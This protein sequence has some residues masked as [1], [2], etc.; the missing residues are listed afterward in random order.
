MPI[1]VTCACGQSFAANDSLAGKRVK[2]PK[3]AQPLQIPAASAPGVAQPMGPARPQTP[4]MPAG[5]AQPSGASLFD[6]IGLK[7]Q[8]AGPTCPN[9][10]ASMPANAILCVQ[11]GYNMKLGRQI[12]T[13]S[14]SG[15]MGLGGGGHGA[16]ADVA[17]TLMA[18]A[19][20]AIEEEAVSEKAKTGEG[21]PWWGYLIGLLL[22]VGF[23]VAMQFFAQGAAIQAVAIIVFL[24]SILASTYANIRILI[25]AFQESVLEGI[26]VCFVPFYAIYYIAT[27]WE[28][29]GGFFLMHLA[30]DFIGGMAIGGAIVASQ[31]QG[32][33]GE[34]TESSQRPHAAY[35]VVECQPSYPVAVLKS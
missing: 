22:V 21:F 12:Q 19:A 20:M 7:A 24:L 33:E 4:Q 15:G 1:K 23:L 27:R 14:T 5:P 16:H 30:A 31:F 18:R 17:N 25:A 8:A 10:R 13:V 9:C 34:E 28:T 11:C 29:V 32:S 35:I 6:E 3:C 2:C 26:L